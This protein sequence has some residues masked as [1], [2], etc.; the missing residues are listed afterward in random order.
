MTAKVFSAFGPIVELYIARDEKQETTGSAWQ[1]LL[2]LL[3]Y[4][5]SF[6]F[7]EYETVE[8]ARSALEGC[9]GYRLDK[10]H[11][12]SVTYMSD[13]DKVVATPQELALPEEAFAEQVIAKLS[14]NLILQGKSSSLVV[15]SRL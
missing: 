6:A 5:S 3:I 13:F 10:K 1:H 4:H 12:F 7:V 8:Q 14:I 11:V 9:N 15:E 2:A